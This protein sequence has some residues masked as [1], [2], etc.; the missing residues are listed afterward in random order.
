MGIFYLGPL[1]G[2]L[3]APIIGGALSQGF[4]WRSTQWFLVA[5]GSVI[6]LGLTF[7]LPETL[8]KRV[9]ML[10]NAP[11]GQDGNLVTEVAISGAGDNTRGRASMAEQSKRSSLSLRRTVSRRSVKENTK[12]WIKLLKRFFLDPLKIILLL[13]FPAVAVTVYYA[14]I[15]FGSLYF[16]N[17]SIETTFSQPPYSFSTLIIGLLYIPNSLGYFTAS[18]VG[19]RWLD[20]IMK[21]EA[22]KKGRYDEKGGLI[23]RPEDRM[24]ENAWGAAVL[25]PAALIWYGWSVQKG[26]P[27]IVPVSPFSKP[28][29]IYDS[30]FAEQIIANFFFGVGSMIIFGMATTMLTEFMPRKASTGIAVNNFVRNIFSCVGGVVAAPILSAVGN[31]WVCTFLGLIALFS[32]FAVIWAMKRYSDKWREDMDRKMKD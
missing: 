22:R 20:H 21:R 14:A 32:G 31:G 11:E 30:N 7:L 29:L 15:T 6:L 5:W 25:F 18:V 10:S 27:W 9:D 1:C 8:I 28:L 4:G 12:K 3:F 24:K 2:P 17:I 13:R 23:F 16:L 19:G 26:L